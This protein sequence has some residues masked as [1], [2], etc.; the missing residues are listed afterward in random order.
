[1]ADICDGSEASPELEMLGTT[2]DAAFTTAK[3]LMEAAELSGRTADL[4]EAVKRHSDEL[5]RIN[6]AVCDFYEYSGSDADT[7][8][9]WTEPIAMMTDELLTTLGREIGIRC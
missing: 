1:M 3:P 4:I 8:D 7:W 9:S 6:G 2:M 5:E